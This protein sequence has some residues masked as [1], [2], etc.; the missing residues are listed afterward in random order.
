VVHGI[1]V[2]VALHRHHKCFWIVVGC[3]PSTAYL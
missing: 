3:P 2:I 1:I